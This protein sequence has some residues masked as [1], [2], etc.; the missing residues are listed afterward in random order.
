[1]ELDGTKRRYFS[2]RWQ[3]GSPKKVKI[4]CLLARTPPRGVERNH[5]HYFFCAPSSWHLIKLFRIFE[6]STN[7]ALPPSTATSRVWSVCDTQI[8]RAGITVTIL[9]GGVSCTSRITSHKW[10][11]PS[12]EENVKNSRSGELFN[13]KKRGC[14]TKYG[15]GGDLNSNWIYN[16]N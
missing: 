8:I 6:I 1:M 9:H 3:G 13:F 5:V 7:T 11:P 16:A 10:L 15:G 14:T 2:Q 4:L 12:R